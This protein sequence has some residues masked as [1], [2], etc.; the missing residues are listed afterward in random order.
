MIPS[1]GEPVATTVPA[2]GE[3]IEA[4]TTEK[5]AA[6]VGLALGIFFWLFLLAMII[7]IIAR[8]VALAAI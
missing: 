5:A 8:Y 3:K 4:T 7:A 6:G 1:A 2:P